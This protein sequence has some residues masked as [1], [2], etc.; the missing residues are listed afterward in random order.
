MTNIN[1]IVKDLCDASRFQV[2]HRHSSAG[3]A[4]PSVP[5]LKEFMEQMK[6][7]LFPGFSGPSEINANNMEFYLGTALDRAYRIIREQINRGFCFSCSEHCEE[8][9]HQPEELAAQ[10]IRKLP[11]VKQL[12]ATDVIAAY[13]GDPAA[14]SYGEAI[15]CYPSIVALTYQRVAHALLELGVPLIPRIITEMAHSETGIDIHPGATV[16]EYFFIDH[17]TGVVI[18]ETTVIGKNVRLYQGV[19]LGAKSFPLDENG[20][21]IKGI[22]RHPIVE[23]DVIVYSNS[24]ILGRVTIGKGSVIGGNQWITFDVPANTKVVQGKTVTDNI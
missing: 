4:M 18:G 7:I 13:N 1:Q 2:L 14:L 22:A 15:F 17:G 19:T 8:C 5:E 24:T 23:D 11:E 12:L 3:V 9:T 6:M 20:K 16:G 21:P 10:F